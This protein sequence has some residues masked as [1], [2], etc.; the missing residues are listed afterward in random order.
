MRLYIAAEVKGIP[1]DVRNAAEEMFANYE[2]DF[3]DLQ[4]PPPSEIVIKLPSEKKKW[5][6]LSDLSRKIEQNLHVFDNRLNI[7]AVCASYKVTN[8]EEKDIPCVTVFVLGKKS[9][10]AG[11][12]DVDEI[13]KKNGHLFDNAEFD[14]VE[15]Y[16]K[17]AHGTKY[18]CYAY[19]LSGG[20]GI[21]V[22]GAFG[23][24][25]G[26]FLEDKERTVYILSNEHVLHPPKKVKDSTDQVVN[27]AGTS[28]RLSEDVEGTSSNR[29]NKHVVHPPGL[30]NNT[31]DAEIED[32]TNEVVQFLEDEEGE[33]DNRLNQH[34][35]HPLEVR[36]DRN[37]VDTNIIIE[38]PAQ[39]DYDEMLKETRSCLRE[40]E[41][42]KSMLEACR[43]KEGK[44][45]Q[46]A[47]RLMD[48]YEE[49]ITEME[50][51]YKKIEKKKPREIG[52]YVNGLQCTK[53]VPLGN[54]NLNIFVDAAIAKL[55]VKDEE[56][57]D[58]KLE[59]RTDED[60]TKRCPL[61]GFGVLKNGICPNGKIIDLKTCL[62]DEFRKERSEL[63]FMKIGQGTGLTEDGFIDPLMNK[64]FVNIP[65]FPKDEPTASPLSH[66]PFRYCKECIQSFSR[67]E[68]KIYENNHSD[69]SECK[70]CGG[71][72][73]QIKKGDKVLHKP[74]CFLWARNILA[75][76]HHDHRFCNSGD[77]GALVFDNQGRAWGLVFGQYSTTSDNHFCLA[78]PLSAV[79]KALEDKT[80][81]KGLKLW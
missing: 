34:V 66:V 25:L 11:E 4:R 72:I 17:P 30:E 32:S 38:Q 20:V 49:N 24:T 46:Y 1:D 12:T 79:L 9:I 53:E 28:G 40:W 8:F 78:S 33:S 26:G 29:S 6:E 16:Y 13:R 18:T 63:R 76:R 59:K 55:T 71:K 56:L 51:S 65:S 2:I 69:E 43:K 48:S 68:E 7:T 36:S 60:E 37:D 80:G 5:K 67:K 74:V 41:K 10:P 23:G 19:P 31:N 64:L 42:K 52:R 62:G 73:G 50:N 75:F 57:N 14:V 27:N 54:E 45:P 15:G 70:K 61:Y 39:S 22:Q 58:M 47:P 81:K 21:G 3:Q 77:S 35:F 44:D